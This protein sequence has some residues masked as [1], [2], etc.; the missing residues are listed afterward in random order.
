MTPHHLK[1]WLMNQRFASMYEASCRTDAYLNSHRVAANVIS[2]EG[3]T[4]TVS[5]QLSEHLPFS[6]EIHVNL[7][8][9]STD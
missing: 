4:L 2:W 1:L 5:I 7:N 3:S 9:R 6:D 8:V